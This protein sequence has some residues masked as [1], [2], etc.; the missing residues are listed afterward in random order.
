MGTIWQKELRV[1]AKGHEVCPVNGTVLGR[2]D[3]PCLVEDPGVGA[4]MGEIRPDK[5]DK[6]GYGKENR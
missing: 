3:R 1:K 2:P 6:E 4:G 5:E